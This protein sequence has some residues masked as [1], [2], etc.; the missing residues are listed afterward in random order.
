MI[1][2]GLFLAVAAGHG[3]DNDE[4]MRPLLI[5]PA[6]VLIGLGAVFVAGEVDSRWIAW[7]QCEDGV[8]TIEEDATTL[9]IEDCDDFYRKP[10]GRAYGLKS[11]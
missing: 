11:K 9:V 5:I 4:S 3:I 8:T 10:E 1:T 6:T 7:E 2:M